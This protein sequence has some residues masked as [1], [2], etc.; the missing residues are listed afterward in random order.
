[1]VVLE[2]GR[3]VWFVMPFEVDA[4]ASRGPEQGSCGR[5]S[6]VALIVE[7]IDGIGVTRLSRWIFNCYVI[8]DGGEGKT[9]VVD[10]GLPSIVVDLPVVLR[11]LG[12]DK[13][14]VAAV[15]ATHAHSD[16]VGGAAS[17][18]RLL[19]CSVHLPSRAAAYLKGERPR[20]PGPRDV[21]KIGPVLRDQPFDA[22]ALVGLVSGAA[23]AGYAGGRMRWR[24]PTPITDLSDGG[25]LPDSPEWRV[26]A[27]PGH[28][29]DSLSFHHTASRT[30]MSGDAVLAK[31][32]IAWCTP[33]TVDR[34]VADVT[35]DR[36]A[37]LDV[38][39]LL[40]GHG[41]PVAGHDVLRAAIPAVS[42][43]L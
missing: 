34:P 6:V 22:R 12:I 37:E 42:R 9:I 13:S 29:D 15:V 2:F 19:G 4:G 40:P 27:S 18:A 41:G 11:R 14:R 7:T 10:A 39:H 23:R 1:M 38:D 8:H 36:L 5:L 31:G 17:L 35:N 21:V 33:E 30:L 25:R 32:G 3:N 20:S 28:T 26:I 24:G 43:P 16:H